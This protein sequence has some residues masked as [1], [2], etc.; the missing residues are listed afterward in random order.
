MRQQSANRA[1]A[2]RAPA[3]LERLQL[4]PP[5][6]GAG[7]V[8]AMWTGAPEGPPHGVEDSGTPTPDSTRLAYRGLDWVDEDALRLVP[9]LRGLTKLQTLDLS[10]NMLSSATSAALVE[11]L[12]HNTSLTA[13]LLNNN[14]FGDA[15][16]KAIATALRLNRHTKLTTLDLHGQRP[17]RLRPKDA[18]DPGPPISKVAAAALATA[19]LGRRSLLHFSLNLEGAWLSLGQLQGV[20]PCLCLA[21]SLAFVAT[22]LWTGKHARRTWP[23]ITRDEPNH[24]AMRPFGSHFRARRVCRRW[25]AFGDAAGSRVE[26]GHERAGGDRMVCG[27]TSTLALGEHQSR[28]PPSLRYSLP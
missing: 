19:V 26:L 7:S 13:L 20:G 23:N 2:N 16:V 12:S 4:Q 18:A 15:C 17:W 25:A 27:S 21:G 22:S 9:T 6:G 11:Y 8:A 14:E 28:W 5:A 3:P 1:P 24:A 10:H